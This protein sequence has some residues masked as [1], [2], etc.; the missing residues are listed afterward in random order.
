MARYWFVAA[1][2]VVAF[3]ARG[4][5]TVCDAANYIGDNIPGALDI[6]LSLSE[7]GKT[8]P[9]RAKSAVTEGYSRDILCFQYQIVNVGSE[10]IP[11]A[12][13]NLVDDYRAKDL[14]KHES[15]FRNRARP[16]SFDDPVKAPT[17]IKGLRAAETS[18]T[19]WRTVE[20]ASKSK[21]ANG[22]RT[23]AFS[24][25]KASSLDPA[26]ADAVKSGLLPD[27]EVAIF[28]YNAAQG[29]AAPVSDAIGFDA[30]SVLSSSG[31]DFKEKAS[32][33]T[34]LQVNA[35]GPS[36]DG[37]YAFDKTF[38]VVEHPLTIEWLVHTPDGKSVSSVQ[39]IKIASYSPFPVSLSQQFC[40]R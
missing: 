10:T 1:L 8:Y 34:Y 14:N 7:D 32:S 31:I 5:P 28:D 36:I 20:D 19:A 11:L 15:R 21:D 23:P 29:K 4:A 22:S 26:V 6:S 30:G 27:V 39:C 17:K 16:T 13:W 12:F 38:Y 33:Y 25:A 3:P 9:I 18:A 2:V 40:I 35:V 24:F 37:S